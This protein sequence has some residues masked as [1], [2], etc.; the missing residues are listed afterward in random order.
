MDFDILS[1]SSVSKINQKTYD[2][3][4]ICLP[5]DEQDIKIDYSVISTS[6]IRFPIWDVE[7]KPILFFKTE[8]LTPSY[9]SMRAFIN[10]LHYI[11]ESITDDNRLLF[12]CYLGQSRS[13]AFAILFME[14]LGFSQD[15]AENRVRSK[16]GIYKPN[17][18]ILKIG[19]DIIKERNISC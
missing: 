7:Y 11:K 12:H 16:V 15:E 3:T 10:Q 2:L 1:L 4:I 19:R 14:I 6:Y 8:N 5:E 13:V 17:P 18:L 9:E